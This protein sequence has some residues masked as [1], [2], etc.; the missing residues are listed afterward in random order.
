MAPGGDET[1]TRDHRPPPRGPPP[2]RAPSACFTW[3]PSGSVPVS[4][5]I[6]RR[7]PTLGSPPP[8]RHV[9]KAACSQPSVR[10]S[11]S[12]LLNPWPITGNVLGRPSLPDLRRLH[13][14][15]SSSGLNSA[16]APS[17]AG[18]PTRPVAAFR[19]GDRARRRHL[20]GHPS[21]FVASTPRELT[22]LF[23]PQRPPAQEQRDLG[24]RRR[25]GPLPG[26]VPALSLRS[27]W[28]K[29]VRR[30]ES[31]LGAA[32]G[33]RR[34]CVRERINSVWSFVSP[35]SYQNLARN[36]P[37]FGGR[38]RTAGRGL[39]SNCDVK[40]DT[41]RPPRPRISGRCC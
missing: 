41:W 15:I 11:S 9:S 18:P 21:V 13:G 26:P 38:S 4:N 14:T 7:Q 27:P 37:H 19:P 24:R 8:S 3:L 10:L 5:P 25:R 2:T 35:Q 12:P 34:R 36:H 39:H 30:R 20:Q 28:R 32:P 6:A 29:P 23:Q 22:S 16:T 40:P 33:E 17:R 1:A 31:D